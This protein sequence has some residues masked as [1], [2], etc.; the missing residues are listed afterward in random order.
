ML[1]A[2]VGAPSIAAPRVIDDCE[3]IKEA[4]AYN[5][6]L[7]SFGPMRGQ[8]TKVYPG[9]ATQ[10]AQTGGKPATRMISRAPRAPLGGA[11]TRGPRGRVRM[12]FTPD[13]R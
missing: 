8:R 12:E 4:D 7:A 11:L 2:L 13:G 3:A 10:G 1:M 6:C 5:N 9:I